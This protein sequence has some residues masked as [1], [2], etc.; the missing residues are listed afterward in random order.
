MRDG[1]P[2]VHRLG[3]WAR[4]GNWPLE[5]PARPLYSARNKGKGQDWRLQGWPTG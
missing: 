4:A 5:S 1:R 2:A 3:T